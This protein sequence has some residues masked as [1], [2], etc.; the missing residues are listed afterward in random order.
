MHT[1]VLG[2]YAVYYV[3]YSVKGTSAVCPVALSPLLC[4]AAAPAEDSPIRPAARGW[5]Q[6]ATRKVNLGRCATSSTYGV[7]LLC[8]K[9]DCQGIVSSSEPVAGP[10]YDM[11]IP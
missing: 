10:A 5:L 7:M 1:I 9:A 8:L 6:N 3:Y 11:Y 2:T 4:C